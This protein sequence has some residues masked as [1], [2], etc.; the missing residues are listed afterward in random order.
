MKKLLLIFCI[1]LFLTACGAISEKV[2]GDD[3]NAEAGNGKPQVGDTV[4]FKNGPIN[5][6]EG[7]IDK[8]DGGKYEIRLNDSIA[9]PDASEIYALPKAGSKTDVKPG[10][11][12]V[13]FNYD[14]YWEG[15]EVK[16][17]TD[18]LVEVEKATGGKLNVAHDKIIKVS[19]KGIADIKQ[20]IEAKAFEDLGKT[21]KPFL[22]KD[23]KPKEGEKVAAQWSF[24]SWHVAVIKHINANNI[25]IDWQ[26]G[27]SDGTVA[28][29]KVAPYPTAASPMP[30]A[31]DYVILK[32]SSDSGEWKFAVVTSVTGQEAEVKLADGKTQKVKNTEFIAMS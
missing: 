30:K 28:T 9:K 16:N 29:D 10:D 27:W 8:T 11:I 1:G 18:D 6:A 12:V 24:G 2:K 13:A 5:Y 19:P 25:D 26:N 14:K 20:N 15:G 22:P 23:W 4:L 7:K 31:N 21:K 32:P 17:V 3:K